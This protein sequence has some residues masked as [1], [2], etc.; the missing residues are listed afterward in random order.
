MRSALLA[1]TGL[2]LLS[3]HAVAQPV[4]GLYVGAAGGVGFLQNERIRGFS[5]AGV[6]AIAPSPGGMSYKPGYVGLGSIGY[7]FGNG[8]R[9][10]VEGDYRR[11][12]RDFGSAPSGVISRSGS[13]QK[14]GG[15][16]NVL[17]DMDIGSPYV[18]PYLGAGAGYQSVTQ[19]LTQTGSN[20]SIERINA[21]KGAFAYQAMF[22][23]SL[24]IPGV[25]GLSAT[26]EY[27]YLGLAGTRSY[28]G[29]LSNA[30]VT[31]AFTRKTSDNDTHNVLVGLR[32]AFNVTP[33]VMVAAT[34]VTAA[35][36]PAAARSYLVFFDWDRADLTDRSRQIIAEAASASTKVAATR[37]EVAGH[38]DRSGTPAYNLGLSRKRAAT[39][40]A[41]LVR[42]GV[43]KAS[44][45]INSFG[46]TMPLVPT[47]AGVREPQNRR[48]EIVLK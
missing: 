20:G 4:S 23:A 37:I 45:T 47:A 34:T 15:M 14:F 8:V 24:P 22:G 6:T 17:F 40:A 46:D 12:D 10:E 16:G 26:I 5:P 27:R 29:T 19:K 1:A 32:Y 39:V 9:L 42:L 21:D 25:V 38:A 43:A 2:A 31:T 30:G 36:A 13:E 48:V 35:P 44:I 3:T 11:N 33:P 41:E 7:G 18:F 28:P